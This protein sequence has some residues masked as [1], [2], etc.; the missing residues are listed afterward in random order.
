M[1][2]CRWMAIAAMV[3][4][5]AWAQTE[6]SPLTDRERLLLDKIAALEA[7]LSAL[8]KRLEPEKGVASAVRS[9]PRR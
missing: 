6:P 9:G 4:S 2:L 1:R 7:R 8:E 3:G 5:A